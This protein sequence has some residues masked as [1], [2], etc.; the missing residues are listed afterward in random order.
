MLDLLAAQVASP[1]QFVKGLETLY[2]EGARVFVEVG[3]KKALHGFVDDVLGGRD[4]CRRAVHQPPEAGRTWP[5]STRRSAGC[6]AAGASDSGRRAA[7]GA[8][9]PAAGAAH[10]AGRARA[11]GGRAVA[12]ASR[13]AAASGDRY[14][15][16]GRLFAEFL[17]R[18]AAHPRRRRCV[19]A[20]ASRSSSP[21]P[22]WACPAR[23]RVFDDDQRGAHLLDGEQ[24][25]DVIPGPLRARRWSTSTSRAW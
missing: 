4:G 25:I 18:G 21:A 20:R 19:R 11:L 5:R 16:L 23:E 10:R 8:A 17:E 13:D 2:A 14:A 1:V 24:F 15:E 7:A 3:P 22:R 6:Y 12:A 9:A